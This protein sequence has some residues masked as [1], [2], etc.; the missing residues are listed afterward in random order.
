MVIPGRYLPIP[1]ALNST[2]TLITENIRKAL[3]YINK[4][5]L[6]GKSVVLHQENNIKY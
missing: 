5:L 2:G 6:M 4:I 1:L 3:N